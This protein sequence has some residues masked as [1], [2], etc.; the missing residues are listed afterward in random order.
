LELTSGVLEESSE[1]QP[2][3]FATCYFQVRGLLFPES[4]YSDPDVDEDNPNAGVHDT[5]L[6]IDGDHSWEDWPIE[7]EYEEA[8]DVDFYDA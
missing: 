2:P 8:G 1:T 4:S 6:L 5:D 7:E 3:S